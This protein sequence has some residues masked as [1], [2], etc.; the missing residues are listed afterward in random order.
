MSRRHFN[1]DGGGWPTSKYGGVP[2]NEAEET[3][4]IDDLQDK[5]TEIYKRIVEEVASAR[6]GVLELMDAALDRKVSERP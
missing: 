2:S 4:L 5:K 6:P 3:K 1:N